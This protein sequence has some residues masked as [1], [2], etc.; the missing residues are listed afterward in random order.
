MKSDS[1]DSNV[2]LSPALARASPPNAPAMDGGYIMVLVLERGA[3]RI[4]ATRFPG[5]NISTRKSQTTRYGGEKLASVM[6][7]K[8]SR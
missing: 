6:V 3:P 1:L 7:T 4:I 2:W 5:M 8:T